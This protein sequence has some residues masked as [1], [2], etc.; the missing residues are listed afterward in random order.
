MPATIDLDRENVIVTIDVPPKASFIT[1]DRGETVR[2]ADLAN[3]KVEA[4]TYV[5]YVKLN[6]LRDI[7]T[8]QMTIII[9]EPV[10]E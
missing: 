6:D 3:T 4:G 5:V 10:G 8:Y 2:I 7:I 1:L 9:S